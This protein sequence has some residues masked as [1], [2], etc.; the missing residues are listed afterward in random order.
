MSSSEKTAGGQQ[1]AGE[2]AS[3]QGTANPTAFGTRPTHGIDM[4]P[5]S[6]IEALASYASAGRLPSVIRLHSRPHTD[7][8]GF[9]PRLTAPNLAPT[10]VARYFAPCRRHVIPAFACGSESRL[11]HA[12]TES[13]AGFGYGCEEVWTY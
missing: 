6:S 13:A 1:H 12:H 3:A 9:H 11:Y 10:T 4:R 5:N 2:R 7:H 8:P